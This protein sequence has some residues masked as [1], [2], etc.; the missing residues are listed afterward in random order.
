MTLQ[1]ATRIEFPDTTNCSTPGEYAAAYGQ[2][3]I[4]VFPV[5]M[6]PKGDAE[7]GF[8]KR[9][10]TILNEGGRGRSEGGF[11]Y[12]T[13][14]PKQ[15]SGWWTEAPD[16]A[17]GWF[18]GACGLVVLDA[19]GPEGV[20]S[21]F[22]AAGGTLDLTTTF[23]IRTSGK[24]GGWHVVFD[25][26]GL[27]GCIGNGSL[28]DIEGEARGDRGYGMLPDGG[29]YYEAKSVTRSVA[30]LPEWAQKALPW[31]TS[32]SHPSIV[33]VTEADEDAWIASHTGTGTSQGQ[34]VVAECVTNM[35]A[36]TA[37][38][39]KTGRH[40]TMN[41]EVAGLL[42][43]VQH[44]RAHID[45][46][47][48]K[49]VLRDTFTDLFGASERWQ[50][51]NDF[52]RFWRDVVARRV[53]E[54]GPPPSET[55]TTAERHG[56]PQPVDLHAV[57]AAGLTQIVPDV[58][59]RQDA[60]AL[61]YRGRLNVIFGTPEAGK[62]WIGLIAIADLVKD[63]ARTGK[64]IDAVFF[65]FEDDATSYLTRMRDAGA[66]PKDV[67]KHTSY[68]SMAT[69]IQ[70][71]EAGFPGADTADLI[72]VDTT[73]SAMTLD[74]L[75]PLGNKDAL[76]FIN[77]VRA[78]KK[79]SDAAW[80]L[81][82]HEPISTGAGR[83][84]AIGAQSKLGAVDGA[85]YRA[86]AVQQPRPGHRGAIALYLTK[87]RPGGVRQWAANP[88][89]HGIQHAA[90]IF[91][92]PIGTENRF[93]FEIVEPQGVEGDAILRAT[94][95][96]VTGEWSSK[97]QI[98][99]LVRGQGVKRRATAIRDTVVVLAAEGLLDQ[100][101]KGNYVQYRKV[102]EIPRP[103][104]GRTPSSQIGT[105]QPFDEGENVDPVWENRVV[106]RPRDEADAPTSSHSIP[107]DGTKGTNEA[108]P[109]PF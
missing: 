107:M 95:L 81:M 73:N 1:Q 24:G 79:G 20:A 101:A 60:R 99:E 75:D 33:D 35:K 14:D 43:Y 7:G 70:T 18:P 97:N 94:I 34:T 109:D 105:N 92:N 90:T 21:L 12:A 22:D 19:D 52:D 61:L 85:Q 49:A 42:S 16:A 62:T 89:E 72:V 26:D 67:A 55:I 83:R 25:R 28:K 71:I 30:P 39:V 84:Q 80:L 88:D 57:L 76:T 91:M 29:S 47:E 2:A 74:D 77:H 17:I 100:E 48:A 54:D 4:P 40:P 46:A 82:D 65:D 10:H 31:D 53:A 87:D 56:G 15:I 64:G 11:K 96:D 38:D 13:T 58:F 86:F 51:G 37:G 8:H 102:A 98:E 9:P 66:D 68:Y 69:P 44:H 45:I 103:T 104:S 23:Q 6:V 106:R 32:N 50:A 59:W 63:A 3:G 93:T 108:L 41:S 36:A 5:V 27:E 78:L